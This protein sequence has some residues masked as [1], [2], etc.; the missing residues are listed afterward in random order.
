MLPEQ[1]TGCTGA[2]STSSPGSANRT[3]ARVRRRWNCCDTLRPMSQ[4]T[5]ARGRPGQEQAVPRGTYRPFRLQDGRCIGAEA[6]VRWRRPAEHRRAA[7]LH[8]SRREHADVG[9]DHL[10]GDGYRGCQNSAAGCAPSGRPPGDPTCRPRSSDAAAASIASRNARTHR[11]RATAG[12][13]TDRARPADAITESGARCA[14]TPTPARVRITD[15]RH[16]ARGRLP[17]SAVLAR[18]LRHRQA[19]PPP[20]RADR[21]HCP[22]PRIGST[23][24]W[25]S[26]RAC[27]SAEGVERLQCATLRA[28][29]IPAAQGYR[30]S[31]A[32]RGRLHRRH[33]RAAPGGG[34]RSPRRSQADRDRCTVK[35]AGRCAQTMVQTR[36]PGA[37]GETCFRGGKVGAARRRQKQGAGNGRFGPARQHRC[38]RGGRSLGRAGRAEPWRQRMLRSRRASTRRNVSTSSTC[39][40]RATSRSATSR[41]R[42]AP[43]SR[44]CRTSPGASTM[45]PRTS[46]CLQRQALRMRTSDAGSALTAARGAWTAARRASDRPNQAWAQT[47]LAEAQFRQHTLSSRAE[48]AARRSIAPAEAIGDQVLHGRAPWCPGPR[49]NHLGRVEANNAPGEQSWRWRRRQATCS[50]RRRR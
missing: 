30:F 7:G 49:C 5:V 47:R 28:A 50:A 11:S 24:G 3:A 8:P 43:T 45:C 32:R 9:P 44:R 22:R 12:A 14:R 6:L 23:I 13:R 19:R 4:I 38:A 15:R 2:G 40:P 39:A 41:A 29:G 20:G 26:C 36:G 46:P 42:R 16:R 35:A 34:E 17:A 18:R 31:P 10:L 25:C 33:R 21:R 1:C 27:T 37:Q 48:A